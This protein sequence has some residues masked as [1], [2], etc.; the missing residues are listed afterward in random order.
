[1]QENQ[2]HTA[3]I[4][5]KQAGVIAGL[6]ISRLVYEALGGNTQIEEL[7]SDGDQVK[8]GETVLKLTG[9]VRELLAGER[10]LLNFLGRLSGI[11]TSAALHL[12][13]QVGEL[14]IL[15][16]TRK[17]TPGYRLLEKYAVRV[18]GMQN[19]RLG[20]YD[21]YM[22]KDNHIAAAG[23]VR[24]ALELVFKHR[25]KLC[26]DIPVE[27]EVTDLD[28]FREAVAMNPDIIM[29]DHFDDE[30]IREVGAIPHNSIQLELSGNITA[31][32]I[33]KLGASGIK[34]ISIGA[35]TH[36]APAFDF[37]MQIG[38]YA[39]QN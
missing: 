7:A 38:N 9:P 8:Q 39:D 13:E 22:I 36:S 18:G 3:R 19:H 29:L 17:T 10:I 21:Q 33:G 32:R 28:Q 11:A 27:I 35:V 31:D 26:E 25:Q 24:P 6:F 12:A 5:A 14:P 20:L 2:L 34:F 30:M 16:D 23:G 37:S 15:L 1:F 4:V